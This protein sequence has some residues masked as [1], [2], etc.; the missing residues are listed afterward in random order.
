MCKYFFNENLQCYKMSKYFKNGRV[1]E[2]VTGMNMAVIQHLS[3]LDI[4]MTFLHI[5]IYGLTKRKP[6]FKK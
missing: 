3:L 6:Q 1:M 5:V 4:C 2:R